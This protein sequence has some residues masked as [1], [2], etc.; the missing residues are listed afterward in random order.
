METSNIQTDRNLCKSFQ[1]P[2]FRLQTT[3]MLTAVVSW[4]MQDLHGL[5]LML[6]LGRGAVLSLQQ[7][8]SFCQY[9]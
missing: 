9:C 8:P 1:L 6:L 4:Q 5:S 2:R 3:L 7:C